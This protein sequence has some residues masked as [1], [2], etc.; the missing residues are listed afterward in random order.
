[1]INDKIGTATV[2][3]PMPAMPFKKKATNATMGR[4]RISVNEFTMVACFQR[5]L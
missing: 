2:L 3:T 5:A 1:M 4:E